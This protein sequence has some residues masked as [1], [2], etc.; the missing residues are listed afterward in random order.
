M[1]AKQV[2][3]KANQYAENVAESIFLRFGARASVIVLIPLGIWGAQKFDD[4]RLQTREIAQQVETF[5]M[6]LNERTAD[7]YTGTQASKD[8]AAQED[9]DERQDRDR[10][11]VER[12]VDTLEQRWYGIR[13]K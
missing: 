7:R 10:T 1:N 12:R 6:R 5:G 8:W 13:Q 9:R 2:A 3:S 4:M 11:R